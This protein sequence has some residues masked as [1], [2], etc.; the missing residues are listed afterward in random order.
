[1]DNLLID[2][3]ATWTCLQIAQLAQ[4]A[5][6]EEVLLTP[7]PGLVDSA[8]NGAHRDLN[9]ELMLLSAQTLTPY[10]TDMSSVAWG[11]PTSKL[12]REKIGEIGR[13]AESAMLLATRQVNTHRGAIWALGLI[14]AATAQNNKQSDAV[15]LCARAGAIARLNDKYIPITFSKGKIVCQRYQVTGAKEEAQQ[16]FPSILKLALPALRASRAKGD[17]E[18]AA[19]LN[20]LLVLMANI[21]DTCVL[22]RGGENA[23]LTV[24]YFCQ[25]IIDGGGVATENGMSQLLKLGE[26][27]IESN[28]SPG[29][30]A[31][32]L[33]ATL[34]ID[35]LENKLIS[36][37]NYA[38][39]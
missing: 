18:Q 10:F 24:Q 3:D 20:A 8:D 33:S 26:M 34:F 5:L 29:G 35:A 7:K 4:W 27:M 2:N 23:L 9:L 39:N 13:N 37:F 31:D 30:A 15:S 16:G 22:S 36:R 19:R 32:L 38:T 6:Q 21:N 14:S 28:L 12:L 17:D 11:Q 25:E 1:M